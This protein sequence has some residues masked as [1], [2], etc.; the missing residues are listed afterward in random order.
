MLRIE[1]ELHAYFANTGENGQAVP[2]STSQRNEAVT[3]GPSE[4][5]P[6]TDGAPPPDRDAEALPP[7]ARVNHVAENGP[8]STAGLKIDDFICSFGDVNWLNHANLTRLSGVVQQNME[9]GL[10]PNKLLTTQRNLDQKKKERLLI[11]VCH[12]F[13]YRDQ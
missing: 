1:R 4:Q 2:Y 3:Q 11:C 6:S 5:T 9:V 8:A 10:N 7:F 12:V 13:V